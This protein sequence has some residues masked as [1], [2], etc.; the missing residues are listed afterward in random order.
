ME[1]KERI[2]ALQEELEAAKEELQEILL[3][4]RTYILEAQNPMSYSSLMANS[5]Q[6]DSEKGANENGG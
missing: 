4:I 3:D 5:V 6:S 1:T 2:E